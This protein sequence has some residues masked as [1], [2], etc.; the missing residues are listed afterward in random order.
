MAKPHPPTLH[1]RRFLALP[2]AA[3]TGCS[4]ALNSMAILD[5]SPEEVVRPLN[6]EAEPWAMVVAPVMTMA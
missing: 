2:L 4:V 1:A 6:V 5:D 3:E